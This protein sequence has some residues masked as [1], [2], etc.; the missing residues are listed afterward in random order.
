MTNWCPFIR[1]QGRGGGLC[2]GI[3]IAEDESILRFGIPIDQCTSLCA[4]RTRPYWEIL[5][6]IHLLRV[7]NLLR[8]VIRY[9]DDPCANAIPWFYRHFPSGRRGEGV[10]V[11]LV[12]VVKKRRS[13]SL[14]VASLSAWS[15][16]GGV[17]MFYTQWSDRG[18][19]LPRSKNNPTIASRQK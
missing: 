2:H 16:G 10:V 1:T 11:K 19:S 8:V 15:V 14:Y 9:R 6:T 4:Q 7:V 13:N 12:A 3:A 17:S 18:K 5:R